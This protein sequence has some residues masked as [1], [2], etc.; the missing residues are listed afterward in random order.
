MFPMIIDYANSNTKEYFPCQRFALA[1][2]RRRQALRKIHNI[3]MHKPTS[4]GRQESA[5]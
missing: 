4:M 1:F 5:R 2:I 3:P